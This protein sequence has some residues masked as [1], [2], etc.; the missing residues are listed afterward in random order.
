MNLQEQIS[1]KKFR[2]QYL[3]FGL[4]GVF[5]SW[6]ENVCIFIEEQK[7]YFLHFTIIFAL[8]K[9]ARCSCSWKKA[10]SWLESIWFLDSWI[11]GWEWKQNSVKTIK[12]IKTDLLTFTLWPLIILP[13]TL[14]ALV[15]KLDRRVI[16]LANHLRRLVERKEIARNL[17]RVV[18]DSDHTTVWDVWNDA[19]GWITWGQ[20]FSY[21]R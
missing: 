13:A 21:Y 17:P 4:S 15:Y 16:F 20:F 10:S 19:G 3:V 5:I 9:P 2:K 8:K 18:I 1:F 7:N 6:I 11:G 14:L 12:T